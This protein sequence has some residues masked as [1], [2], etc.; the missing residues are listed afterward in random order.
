MLFFT[1]NT[2]R[3]Q[4]TGHS[5]STQD[6][7]VDFI[8]TYLGDT[9]GDLGYTP[10]YTYSI[11]GDRT[12]IPCFDSRFSLPKDQRQGWWGSGP[13]A[14]SP[15]NPGA[16]RCVFNLINKA[17]K[18]HAPRM[19]TKKNG[20]GKERKRTTT[21]AVSTNNTTHTEHACTTAGRGKTKTEQQPSRRHED[22]NTRLKRARQ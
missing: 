3:R 17:H 6:A 15:G 9:F 21:T 10:V 12:I 2:A 22:L 20:G 16:S 19:E 5:S 8:C 1:K 18:T 14:R 13:S 11:F 7:Q 4:K